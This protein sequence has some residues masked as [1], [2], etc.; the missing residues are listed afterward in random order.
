MARPWQLEKKIPLRWKDEI[1]YTTI[2]IGELRL[3]C[4]Y[5]GVVCVIDCTAFLNNNHTIETLKT[6]SKNILADIKV[7]C[8]KKE[9]PI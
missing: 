4:I 6:V 8:I 1:M 9:N 7:A 3:N 5:R 2:P